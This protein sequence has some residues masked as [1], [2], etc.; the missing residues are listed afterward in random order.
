LIHI[1]SPTEVRV[2]ST[3]NRD[4]RRNILVQAEALLPTIPFKNFISVEEFIIL[5]QSC[6][7]QS[8]DRDTLL[9]VVGNI[10]ED[11]VKTTGDDGISQ[12]VTA[13]TGITAVAD[14][15]LPN[16][17][18]LKPFRTFVEI[19]QPTCS[20]VFRMQDGPRAAL[21]EAD[22]GAWKLQAMADIKEY[23]TKS[24]EQEI[25]S[26]RVVIIA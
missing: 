19:S 25:K 11:N 20:F 18:T 14:V 3:F 15:K 8:V 1:E 9:K 10:K 23:L 21:F 12:S 4:K 5:L 26:E 6:F 13:K 7:V 2:L 22:G 16:P 24:L 17:V